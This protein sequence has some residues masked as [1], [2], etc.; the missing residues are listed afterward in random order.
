MQRR[1]KHTSVTREEFLGTVFSV[2]GDQKF[3]NEDFRS[4]EI[5][6][7]ESPEMARNELGCAKK[8]SYVLQLQC[9]CYSSCVKIR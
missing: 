7:M 6:L 3:Y 1:R 9:D 8:A 4:A 5:E 2:G